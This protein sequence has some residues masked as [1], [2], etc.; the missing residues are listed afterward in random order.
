MKKLKIEIRGL[1]VYC[2]K[3]DK[4]VMI[5]VKD[6][7]WNGGESECELCGSHGNVGVEFKCECGKNHEIELKSW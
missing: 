7:Y 4:E 2:E 6:C 5:D 3:L 1:K